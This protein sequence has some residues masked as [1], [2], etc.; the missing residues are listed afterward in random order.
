MHRTAKFRTSVGMFECS[1]FGHLYLNTYVPLHT[2]A[3]TH[4]VRQTCTEEHT[5]TVET[6]VGFHPD[7][8]L[9]LG[10]IGSICYEN[11]PNEAFCLLALQRC[12]PD[13][14]NPKSCVI[15]LDVF[16]DVTDEKWERLLLNIKKIIYSTEVYGVLHDWK[17]L[18]LAAILITFNQ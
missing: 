8:L 10:S 7:F 11:A 9:K 12:N 1:S 4:Y 16:K 13:F 2:E 18:N 14:Y 17:C 6:I 5:T 15:M 3:H